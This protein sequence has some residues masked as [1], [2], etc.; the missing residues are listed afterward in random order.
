MI[1]M[2]KDLE[3][4]ALDAVV[5]AEEEPAEP[6]IEPLKNKNPKKFNKN[7][8]SFILLELNLFHIIVINHNPIFIMTWI[9]II[10]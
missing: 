6:V 4:E 10:L 1:Q 2:K 9:N 8:I 3:E 5:P 7:D